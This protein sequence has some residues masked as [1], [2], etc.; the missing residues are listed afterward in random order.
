M[1]RRRKRS[2][3]LD[4]AVYIERLKEKLAE[5]NQALAAAQNFIHNNNN[6]HDPLPMLRV[7]AEEGG[8]KIRVLSQK[9]C[10]GL[11]VF[12]LEAIQGLG[13][14]LLQARVSCVHTFSLEALGAKKD[15]TEENGDMDAQLV[16]QAV[17]QAIQRWKKQLTN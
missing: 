10:E 15:N 6:N 4:R 7:E 12:V 16:E 2:V 5:L 9:S 17:S 1:Q 14:D 8:F 13:L 11:L 3:I